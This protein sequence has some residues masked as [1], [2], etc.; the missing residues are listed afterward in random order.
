MRWVQRVGRS[1]GVVEKWCG[2]PRCVFW[3][4]SLQALPDAFRRVSQLLRP[5]P[6]VLDAP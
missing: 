5:L 1:L 2:W 4:F 6:D 3:T